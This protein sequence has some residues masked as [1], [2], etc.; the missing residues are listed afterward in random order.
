VT[1]GNTAAETVG[2][3]MDVVDCRFAESRG[4]S[5]HIRRKPVAGAAIRFE[6]CVIDTPT[7]ENPGS[8]PIVIQSQAGCRRTV[9]G[10][11]FGNLLIVDPV[12]RPFMTYEDWV[13][14]SGV[15]SLTG[16]ITVRRNGTET[17]QKLTRAW[18]EKA[19]PPRV[20]KQVAAMDLAGVTLV[21]A[22]LSDAPPAIESSPYFLR[23]KGEL[24]LYAKAGDTV[25]LTM[26]HEQVGRYGGR[27]LKITAVSPSGEKIAAGE[28][29]FQETASVSFEAPETGLY[30][31]P[32]DAGANRAGVVQSSHPVA[33]SGADAPIRFI[34]IA[35]DLYFLV[36]A[37][38]PEV[39]LLI[40]GEGA[41]EAIKATVF[42][43][44]GNQVWEK[45][46]ITL[47]EMWSP[48]QAAP[49]QDQVWRLR[50]SRPTGVTYEDNYVDIRGIP[51]FLARD[52]Q[53]LLEPRQ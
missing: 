47:P 3:R 18:L 29:P 33:V 49:K 24:V 40:Y 52:P 9:G 22:E 17:T 46:N 48:E 20:Y 45:D 13:G 28:I 25:T 31:L 7:T 10:V 30:R 36:P 19:F 27:P 14:G 2:G 23:K 15:E 44:A 38:T 21:P 51:P 37:G 42:D 6:N 41:G 53:A 50:L 35:G 26:A 11:D 43:P 8:T 5:I 4:T 1:T 12:D 16:T 39:G 34:G 32:V